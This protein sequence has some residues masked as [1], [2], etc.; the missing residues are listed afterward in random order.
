MRK[1]VAEG[2]VR[3]SQESHDEEVRQDMRLLLTEDVDESWVA[4]SLRSLPECRLFRSL[5]L[6]DGVSWDRVRE[7]DTQTCRG[8]VV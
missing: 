7:S 8:P 5:A 3:T 2:Q 6:H 1:E 4:S